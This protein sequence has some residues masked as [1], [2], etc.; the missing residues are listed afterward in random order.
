MMETNPGMLWFLFFSLS[1]LPNSHFCLFVFLIKIWKN[2]YLDRLD[3]LYQRR[4]QSPSSPIEKRLNNT[5]ISVDEQSNDISSNLQSK[6]KKVRW[7]DIEETAL[8]LHKKAGKY[9]LLFFISHG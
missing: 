2:H 8:H 5:T 3:G 1:F 4:N 9:L 7:A 6:K